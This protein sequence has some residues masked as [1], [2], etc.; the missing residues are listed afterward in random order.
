MLSVDCTLIQLSFHVVSVV[1]LPWHLEKRSE[2]IFTLY[3]KHP[4]IL[5]K[6]WHNKG[7]YYTQH[8]MVSILTTTCNKIQ[9]KYIAQ[10]YIILY[11]G[12][13]QPW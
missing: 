9:T 7:A 8:L 6:F 13:Q 11:P 3:N 2:K 5:I 1:M 10:S 4:P 12:Y